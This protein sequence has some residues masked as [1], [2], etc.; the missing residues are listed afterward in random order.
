MIGSRQRLALERRE[1]RGRHGTISTA[2][3]LWIRAPP[4]GAAARTSARSEPRPRSAQAR[5][6]PHRPRQVDVR[7]ELRR[8]CVGD[9]AGGDLEGA[10]VALIEARAAL[11]A[12]IR[13]CSEAAQQDQRA[14]D[15]DAPAAV[16]RRRA[17]RLRSG[18]GGRDSNGPAVLT[19]APPPSFAAFPRLPR[20]ERAG[21][22]TRGTRAGL[23][24][25]R[26]ARSI[27][28]RRW[29]GRTHQ[30]CIARIEAWLEGY[31]AAQ[32]AGRPSRRR[33]Q[34]PAA[35]RTALQGAVRSVAG[36]LTSALGPA[37]VPWSVG[38]AGCSA[39]S[40]AIARVNGSQLAHTPELR[41]DGKSLVQLSAIAIVM[42][43][44]AD[45]RR[46]GQ[47]MRR[48]W[49]DSKAPSCWRRR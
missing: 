19:S 1:L 9:V 23:P 25:A 40:R 45:D 28:R 10:L 17:P 44:P 16:T 15:G 4:R 3:A 42:A 35:T 24:R 8:Q 11:V 32:P 20:V 29:H 7:V 27:S 6:R 33:G 13:G 14:D 31:G 37:R 12:E 21:E 34:A 49:P 39:V 48:P 2:S 30:L 43:P 5:R 38:G 22:S 47:A 18:V 41:G 36:A 46:T 26:S